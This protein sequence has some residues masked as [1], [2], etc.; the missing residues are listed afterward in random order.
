CRGAYRGLEVVQS[1]LRDVHVEDALTW[2]LDGERITGMEGEPG[3]D[4]LQDQRAAEREASL[5]RADDRRGLDR[6][7]PHRRRLRAAL[8]LG[9]VHVQEAVAGAVPGLALLDRACDVREGHQ[10]AEVPGGDGQRPVWQE[11]MLDP[12]GVLR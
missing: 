12:V 5:E 6:A 7:H 11:R 3:G 1:V 8:P 4:G 9:R 10:G 2:L